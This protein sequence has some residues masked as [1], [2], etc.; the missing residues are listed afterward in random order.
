M[1]TV[2]ELDA[3]GQ[4]LGRLASRIA[5]LLRGKDT[6]AYEPR[7]MPDVKVIVHNLDRVVFKGT[8]AVSEIHYRHSGFPGGLTSATLGER[9]AKDKKEVLRMA[10]RGMLPE[11]RT[12]AKLLQHIEIK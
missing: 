5:T 3:S 12:R 7:T 8:K 1:T 11:N 10:V 4:S 2:H 6:P 9:W